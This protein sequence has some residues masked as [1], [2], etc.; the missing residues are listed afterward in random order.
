MQCICECVWL[1]GKISLV[2]SLG[3][4]TESEHQTQYVREPKF[5]SLGLK[6]AGM[7]FITGLPSC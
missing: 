4:W 2:I 5:G 7:P 6:Y 3:D 1:L